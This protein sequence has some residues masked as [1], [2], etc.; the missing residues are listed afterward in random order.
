MNKWI[1]PIH[2]LDFET[3]DTIFPK[4]PKTRPNAKIPYQ[5]SVYSLT[6]IESEPV[7][8]KAYI[9]D[10]LDTDPRYKLAQILVETLKTQGSI[11]S[12]NASFEKSRIEEMATLFPDLR[13]ELLKIKDRLIDLLEIV[14]DNV[15]L[16]DFNGSWSIKSVTP[17]LFGKD[18]SY[19]EMKI[20]N[21]LAAQEVYFKALTE[22]NLEDVRQNLEDYCNKDV[23]EMI[24]IS[25]YLH[26]K[27][28][29]L[30]LV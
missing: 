24:H 16:K 30:V 1:F 4:Y 8:E 19:K 25:K 11:I 13:D 6:T 10:S 29:D 12:Y 18:Q 7:L 2:F 9:A 3:V 23:L 14:R 27:A 21:G 22:N 20:Q 15:Y 5:F 17:A 28:N 26:E